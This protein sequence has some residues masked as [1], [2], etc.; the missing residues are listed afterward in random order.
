LLLL[1]AVKPTG[2]Q[3][4]VEQYNYCGA[5]RS[6]MWNPI[7]RYQSPGDWYAEMRYNY[8]D[9]HTFSLYTGRTFAH[10]GDRLAYSVTPLVGGVVGKFKGGSIGLNL[11]LD[12]NNLFFESQ[13]QYSFGVD[14][15][16]LDFLFA[17]SD[18][19]YQVRPWLFGG[20]SV[21]NTYLCQDE[22]SLVEPGIFLGVE[23]GAWSFPIYTFAPPAG[24]PF[25]V[26]GI[27]FKPRE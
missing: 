19:G 26:V 3:I 27:N 7:V 10:E 22:S 20:I 18:V 2:A 15:E 12:Y 11:T 1:V 24:D 9:N 14:G 8:E 13:S 23:L 21:Q 4:A 6:L 25:F 16:S 5:D 17:W